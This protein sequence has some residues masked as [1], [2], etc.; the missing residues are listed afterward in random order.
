M[1]NGTG[2]TSSFNA[3]LHCYSGPGQQAG[4]PDGNGE[5]NATG[6]TDNDGDLTDPGGFKTIILARNVVNTAA[7]V[8]RP[9]FTYYFRDAL[10]TSPTY[11]QWSHASTLTSATVAN[12]ITPKSSHRL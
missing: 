1:E 3:F 2:S 4:D 11:G 8:N 9:I 10:A 12:S 6:D 7:S 5:T